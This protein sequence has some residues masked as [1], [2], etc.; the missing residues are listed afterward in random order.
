MNQNGWVMGTAADEFYALCVAG[1]MEHCGHELFDWMMGNVNIKVIGGRTKMLK[2]DLMNVRKIDGPISAVIALATTLG[3][4]K[5]CN[6]YQPG[7]LAL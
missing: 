5:E 6:W 3:A 2:P 4:E 7:S 1:A